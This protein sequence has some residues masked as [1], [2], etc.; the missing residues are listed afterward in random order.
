MPVVESSGKMPAAEVPAP[1]A[2]T[3]A[4]T[5]HSTAE[6][7]AAHASTSMTG[8]AA[9]ARSRVGRDGGASQRRGNNNDCNSVQHKF[10]HGC[11]LLL[12]QI[13]QH[14][15]RGLPQR[16]RAISGSFDVF[17]ALRS[18]CSILRQLSPACGNRSCLR[19]PSA[20][21]NFSK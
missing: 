9:T 16:N 10:L 4:T 2:A 15:A 20:S 8:S 21:H 17:T 5:T 3:D 19:R 7:S 11:C 6:V 13:T 14:V 12:F 18:V 1:Q